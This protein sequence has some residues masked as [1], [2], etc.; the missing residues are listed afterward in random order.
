LLAQAIDVVADDK[1][2]AAEATHNDLIALVLQRLT[3]RHNNYAPALIFD[4]L[5]TCLDDL[6]EAFDDGKLV[7]VMRAF[8]LLCERHEHRILPRTVLPAFVARLRT[9]FFPPA[10]S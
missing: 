5:S 10:T 3:D 2:E 4:L 9:A 6:F 7:G 8:E 1:L